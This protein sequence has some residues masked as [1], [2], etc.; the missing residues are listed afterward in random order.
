MFE[1]VGG[2]SSELSTRAQV[3]HSP[4]LSLPSAQ[5]LLLKTGQPWIRSLYFLARHR[6]TGRVGQEHLPLLPR[7]SQDSPQVRGGGVA[8]SGQGDDVMQSV[9]R[10]RGGWEWVLVLG[11]CSLTTGN[12]S[13]RYT[14][15][16]H[17]RVTWRPA[18][19]LTTHFRL[20]LYMYMYYYYLIS[21]ISNGKDA[22]NISTPFRPLRSKCT[23]SY[24]RSIFVWII[25]I[26]CLIFISV[27]F[28][29]PRS[30]LTLPHREKYRRVGST[31]TTTAF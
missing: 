29:L 15:R 21:T 2:P 4:T 27:P 20:G 5:V 26:L 11:G 22:F 19:T 25:F 17:T 6:V 30:W 9:V 8:L 16:H 10:G 18:T 14:T 31:P 1:S 13:A 3:C 12:I 28:D 23:E 24:E 7:S